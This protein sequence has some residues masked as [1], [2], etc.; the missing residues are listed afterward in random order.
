MSQRPAPPQPQPHRGAVGNPAGRYETLR[1][2]VADDGWDLAEDD[3]APM[4][5]MVSVDAT[6]TI[7]AR[8]QSPDVPFDRSI[9]PYRGCEHGCIYCF[10]RPGHAWLGLSPGLDFETRLFAK[11][12]AA[13]L[14][15]AELRKPGYR[16]APL[17]IGTF[18]DPYQ[19]IERRLGIMRQC[20]EVLAAFRHPVTITTKGALVTRD[21]DILAPMAAQG[22]AAVGIS[23]TTLDRDLCR[24]LEPRAAT[25]AMRIEAIRRLAEA[26]IP[27]SVM[28]APVIPVVTDSEMERILAA[29]GEAGATGAQWILLRLP[30]E[31]QD[32]FVEWLDTHFP[33][34]SAHVQSLLRQSRGG[35]LYDPSFATRYR[36]DGAYAQM[37]DQ[38]FRL[39]AR[40][41]GFA[42]RHLP[43][44]TDLFRPPP[45]A[46][47]QLALF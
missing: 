25:P 13:R 17:A 42:D 5:T 45:R 22:L 29:A 24:R 41:L 20:L 37:L 4:A 3:L 44:R 43:L 7:I 18:T 27:T 36:G 26:G 47:D 32:L 23:V 6:R 10:A 40:R 21:I 2:E 30:L 11:P 46:G 15:D 16:P 38:R 9:N 33:G 34:R 35:R 12:D 1:T 19:P 8:N 28:V 39:A 31:V 14:L